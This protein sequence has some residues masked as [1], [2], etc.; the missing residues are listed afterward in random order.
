MFIHIGKKDEESFDELAVSFFSAQKN[1]SLSTSIVSS[2]SS[3]SRDLAQKLS[4]RLKKPVFVS[5]GVISIDRVTKPT[6]EQR[7][8]EEIISQPD[9]F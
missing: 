3:E 9:Y 7:L 6:V 1:E 8:I 2:E 5:G 4:L